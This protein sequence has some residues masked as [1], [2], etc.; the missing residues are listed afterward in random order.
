MT[1]DEAPGFCDSRP[2]AWT[3]DSPDRLMEFYGISFM[4]NR[5]CAGRKDP[6]TRRG[7]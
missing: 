5:S 2:A 7:S 1:W 3:G 6:D 4:E